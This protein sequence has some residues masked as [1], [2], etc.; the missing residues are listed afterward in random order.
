MIILSATLPVTTG[1]SSVCVDDLSGLLGHPRPLSQWSSSAACCL[2][3]SA[4]LSLALTSSRAVS[5]VSHLLSSSLPEV[6]HALW[7]F[8]PSVRLDNFLLPFLPRFPQTLDSAHGLN[9]WAVVCLSALLSQYPSLSASLTSSHG[10]S[11]LLVFSART[12]IQLPSCLALNVRR[13]VRRTLHSPGVIFIFFFLKTS[14]SSVSADGLAS[15]FLEKN[16]S[17]HAEML[18]AFFLHIDSPTAAPLTHAACL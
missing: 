2:G 14:L 16:R 17:K 12:S 8:M 9:S 7:F 4:G 1:D 5:A 3:P 18:T 6:C 15:S 10:H 13:C 11:Q